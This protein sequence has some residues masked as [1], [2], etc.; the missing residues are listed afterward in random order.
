MCALNSYDMCIHVFFVIW[1]YMCG[2]FFMTCV[3]HHYISIF[4]SWHTR[5]ASMP[6]SASKAFCLWVGTALL[7][8]SASSV[9]LMG[10]YRFAFLIQCCCPNPQTQTRHTI[11][12]YQLVAETIYNNQPPELSQFHT[13]H[14]MSL[15][16]YDGCEMRMINTARQES[17][18]WR[19]NG[20]CKRSSWF[21]LAI[22]PNDCR[23]E[24]CQNTH[25]DTSSCIHVR[26]KKSALLYTLPTSFWKFS[27]AIIL[28]VWTCITEWQPRHQ[29][30]ISA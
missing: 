15:L 3:F 23:N 14:L 5:N 1:N 16:H 21:S 20:R 4:H 24:E 9:L 30:E 10:G 19:A 17:S 27:E 26:K 12:V 6:A 2:E 18:G 28:Q 8:W 11:P 13:I 25:L 7:F 29:V 22:Q